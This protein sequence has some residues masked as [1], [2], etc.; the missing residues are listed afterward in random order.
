MTTTRKQ[1]AGS[2]TRRRTYARSDLVPPALQVPLSVMLARTANFVDLNCDTRTPSPTWT[3]R[4][5][6][7]QGAT[8]HPKITSHT[9]LFKQSAEGEHLKG[10]KCRL[11]SLSEEG[12]LGACEGGLLTQSKNHRRR[13]D[14]E[15]PFVKPSLR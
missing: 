3:V 11:R 12:A 10:L 15:T 8:K 4:C 2:K 6:S 13:L 7:H 9:G 5:V 14:K 1:R